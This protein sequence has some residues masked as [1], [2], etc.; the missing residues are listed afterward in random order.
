[1]PFQQVLV[2]L[3]ACKVYR[4]WLFSHNNKLVSRVEEVEYVLEK[5]RQVWKDIWG[6]KDRWFPWKRNIK[7]SLR[8]R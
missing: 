4:Y 1:M 8:E 2:K 5:A 7:E 3:K 6:E